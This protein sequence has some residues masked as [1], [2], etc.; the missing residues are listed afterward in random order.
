MDQRSRNHISIFQNSISKKDVKLHKR[1]TRDSIQLKSGLESKTMFHESASYSG[2][3][4]IDKM[5]ANVRKT[6]KLRNPERV[7]QETTDFYLRQ[8]LLKRSQ[9]LETPQPQRCSMQEI[10]K[11]QKPNKFTTNSRLHLSLKVASSYS[12]EQ[13]SCDTKTQTK[14]QASSAT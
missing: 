2:G 9:P 8:Q 10:Y 3:L 12:G 11:D 1:L 7:K 4:V 5:L 13:S 14:T 6:L